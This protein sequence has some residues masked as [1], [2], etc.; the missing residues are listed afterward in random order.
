MQELVK[1]IDF[2]T[3]KIAKCW[4]FVALSYNQIDGVTLKE[5]KNV[6][7]LNGSIHEE[8]QKQG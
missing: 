5:K 8:N 4:S 6:L 2:C 7:G 3:L 1:M